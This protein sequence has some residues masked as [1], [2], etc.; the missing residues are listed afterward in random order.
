MNLADTGLVFHPA[1]RVRHRSADL[2]VTM[3]GPSHSART[4]RSM[5]SAPTVSRQLVR[6]IERPLMNVPRAPLS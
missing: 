4:A 3:R 6:L 5:Y 2:A 1:G